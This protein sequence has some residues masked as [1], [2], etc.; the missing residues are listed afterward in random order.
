MYIDERFQYQTIERCSN[1]ALHALFIELHLPKNAN[2]VCGVLYR[3]HNSPERFQEYFD[4]T[5]GKLSATGKQIILM[6]DFNINLLH[7]H[8][9]IVLTP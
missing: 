8:T 5:M 6:G 7:V 2:I 9:S 1:E 4:L 3:Q